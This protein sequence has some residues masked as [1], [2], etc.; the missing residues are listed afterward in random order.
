MSLRSLLVPIVFLAAAAS[1]N[2]QS[3]KLRGK[4]EDS[5]GRFVVGC[6]DTQL[7]SSTIDLN[8]Y[9]GTQVEIDGTWNGSATDPAVDVTAIDAI[10]KLFEV[11][12]NGK[13]GG[14]VSFKITSTPGDFGVMFA[15][16][17]VSFL[18]AHRAGTLFLPFGS[19][20][21]VATGFVGAAGTFEVK[22]NVPDDPA[23]DG[24]V[25]YGQ[26][27]VAFVGGGA[28][29]SNPDCITLHQ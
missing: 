12:G 21:T 7:T 27:F 11:G 15:A 20:L 9:V 14:E 10:A 18:P 4:V 1:V 28:A 3:V 5:A 19:M 17:D 6:T 16:L 22:G 29:L 24:L 13:L 23:L 25:A 26:A 8:A 2:A